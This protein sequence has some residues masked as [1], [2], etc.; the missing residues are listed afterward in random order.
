MKVTK[1][2]QQI[3]QT[4]RYSVYVDEK[5]TFSLSESALLSSGIHSG[6]DL[7]AAD[8]K[9]LKR[10]STDDKAYGKALRYVAMRPRSEW[11]LRVYLQ[12]KEAPEPTTNTIVERLQRVGL[13]ND[14]AFARMW[15]ENRRLLKP[16]SR[17][18]LQVELRRKHIAT[19][20]IDAVLLEDSEN[21]DERQVIRDL[22]NRKR[23]RYADDKKLMAYLARQGYS[24]DDIKAALQ[25]MT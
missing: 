18:R 5:Y 16:T 21:T 17:R 23:K 12:H 1:I 20:V 3:K 7:T 13:I 4:N 10:L 14:E 24:Y 19:Q 25:D 11:E 8:V 22:V 9:H 2:Q 6:Q 15:V